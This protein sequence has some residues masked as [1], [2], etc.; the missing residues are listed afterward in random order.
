VR[1]FP[2]SRRH[3]HFNADA[4]A[5]S[6][7]EAG[8]AYHPAPGLGGRRTPRA[9]SRNTALRVAGFRGYADYME[10]PAFREE[11]EKLLAIATEAPTAILCAE[12]LWWRCHR[13]LIAD[14]LLAR[15]IA[16]THILRPGESRPH[17]Y[18]SAARVVDGKLSY[19]EQD[20]LPLPRSK[21]RR[22]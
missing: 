12:A 18:T 8:I 5:R 6:L 2:A 15:G 7:G 19:S 20:S 14:C 21:A 10:T 13:S 9:D 11:I 1:R 17:A 22:T 3:P 16:V 4:L